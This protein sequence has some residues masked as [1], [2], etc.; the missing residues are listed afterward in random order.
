VRSVK[1]RVG[2]GFGVLM[3]LFVALVTVQVLVG[4]RLRAERQRH[5]DRLEQ[6]LNANRT[7]LQNM[8]DAETGV[9]GFQ[10]TGERA[11]LDPYDSGR[12]GA[13]T[14]F[15][16][17]S[18]LTR[19]GDVV[20]LVAVER[21]AAAHWLD[22]YAYPIVNAGVADADE[23]RAVRGRALFDLIRA[24]NV[25]VDTAIRAEQEAV[26]RAD[27]RDAWLVQS[28]FAGLAAAFAAVAL[29]LAAVYQRH[30]LAPL[31]HIRVTLRCLAAGEHSARVEPAGPAEMRAVIGTLNDLAAQ[32]E[33]LLDEEQARGVR[34]ELRQAVAIE[35][36]AGRDTALTARRIA[37]LVGTTLGADEVHA[38]ITAEAGPALDI[39]WPPDVP[40]LAPGIATDV[41]AGR[42]G[43]V[44]TV[45]HVTGA[46]AVPLAGDEDGPAGLLY[47][48]RHANP[49]WSVDERRLL[50]AIA[51]E[52]AHVVRQQR[53]SRRQARLIGELQVLDERKDAFVATV[54]HELRTPLTSILGYL[55]VL[56]EGDSGDL[57][58]TQQRGVSA[59]LRN[60]LRLQET[61]ADLL[62]L[63]RGNGRPGPV[64]VDLAAVVTGAHA[65]LAAAARAKDLVNTVDVQPAWVHGD[66]GQLQ[67][68][69]RNLIE[70]AIKFTHPG[71]RV[72]CW[73]ATDGDDAILTVTDTGIG[74]P[75]DD[76]PGLFAPFHRAANAM[77]QAVQG[78]GLGLAVVRNIVTEHG[79]SV[80]AHSRV[81][82]GSTF[83]ITLPGVTPP[84]GWADEPRA[85]EA[86]H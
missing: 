34:H 7:V 86:V 4:D 22:A 60:A 59:I 72:G 65:G 44:L 10:L 3:L 81:N 47:L 30:L 77:H 35:L 61:V 16:R 24:A 68:A 12:V 27:R 85:S 53:L 56:S 36:R 45:P 26:A 46:V 64:P 32:T 73:L 76:V 62:L 33:R 52:I 75:A 79:G 82:E 80:A 84:A 28:L 74:I 51:W 63:D 25:G 18:E 54:T 69:I 58:P 42:P 37:E 17:M 41:M 39:T 21:Q 5:A 11:F 29:V 50:A 40:P 9:R 15:D 1:G 48:A 38:R 78:S 66:R 20:R 8:T 71:G 23:V 6:A 19:D 55:E 31:E 83:T 70:N 43:D 49:R 13:F 2:V 14:A 67:R 57:S